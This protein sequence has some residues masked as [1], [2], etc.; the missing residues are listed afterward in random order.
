VYFSAND[1]V[2][3]TQLWKSN[4]TTTTMLTG[5]NIAGGGEVPNDLRM[6]GSTL[7]FSAKDGVHGTQLWKSD[8]TAAGT[9][10]V[11]DI[12]GTTTAD[13]T[14]ITNVGGTAYFAAYTTKSGFQ[15]WQTDGTA[16]GTVMDTS[17]ATGVRAPWALTAMGKNLYFL[18][19]GATLWKWGTA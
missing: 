2:H 11:A 4:G 18:A 17:L 5:G 1:G 7:Y 10:M 15:V 19:P 13:V 8:G 14:N 9:V 16:S 6:V 12:N 3:G